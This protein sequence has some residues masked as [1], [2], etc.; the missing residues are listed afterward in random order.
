MEELEVA[1]GG[2]GCVSLGWW[3]GSAVGGKSGGSDVRITSWQNLLYRSLVAAAWII[4]GSADWERFTMPDTSE[5]PHG[6]P[7]SGH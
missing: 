6:Y 7:S 2:A 4:D 5:C 3:G 1:M